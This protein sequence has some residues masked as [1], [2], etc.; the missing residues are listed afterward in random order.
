MV[1][2]ARFFAFGLY[3]IEGFW[4]SLRRKV[5]DT[6]PKCQKS[7]TH[8]DLE[9]YQYC[10]LSCSVKELVSRDLSLL[11]FI[12]QKAGDGHSNGSCGSG[13]KNQ[14]ATNVDW[15]GFQYWSL[16]RD[17]K[18]LV[19]RDFSLLG[20]SASLELQSPESQTV[21]KI[22]RACCE[23]ANTVNTFFLMFPYVYLF[24]ISLPVPQYCT[25]LVI[26]SDRVTL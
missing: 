6:K 13:A 20:F 14:K 15:E 1:S 7:S 19:P 25:I 9:G 4:R 21:Y 18:G 5:T 17:V 16:F 12:Q 3:P 10:S 26:V 8:M 24:I 23:F 22:N 2:V 11:V